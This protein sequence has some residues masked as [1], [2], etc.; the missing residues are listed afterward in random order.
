MPPTFSEHGHSP[1]PDFATTHWS[2]IV[3]AGDATHPAAREAL[4]SL[5]Q[6]YW[7][8]LYEYA[9]RRGHSAGDAADLT[10]GFFAILLEKD[11]LQSASQDRGRFRA[12]LLTAF[13][14]YL[15]N[16]LDKARSLKR[17]AA[18]Q[19]FSMSI[20][21]DD[22]E[23][24]MEPTDE[25]TAEKIFER[26]WAIT[27]LDR[28]LHMLAEEMRQ[29]DRHRLFELCRNCLIG[30]QTD[31]SYASIAAQCSMT[32][33]AVKV[34]VHRMRTR[35]RELLLAEV[36]QT[37]SSETDVAEELQALLRAVQR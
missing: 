28:V 15:L 27:L 1:Q 30:L 26:R 35:F 10:Q 24:P 21:T 22:S 34:A 23:I 29:K 13:K 20:S 2:L 5:C 18:V 8:P 12:F 37:V 9:R 16:E 19:T 32:E 33:A 6:G 4:E 36:S 3:A 7:Q 31:D 17:G 11:Y 14:R 25:T